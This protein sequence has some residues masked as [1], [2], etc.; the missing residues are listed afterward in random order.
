MKTLFIKSAI[1]F[2]FGILIQSTGCIKT[3]H[4]L[5]IEPDGGVTYKLEHSI[6]EHAIVQLKAMDKLRVQL[7]KAGSDEI[8][9]DNNHPLFRAFLDPNA[10]EIRKEL[11]P[12]ESVGVRIKKLEVDARSGWAQVE[13]AL[14]A[15]NLAKVAETDFFKEHGFNIKRQTNKEGKEQ[16]V[17]SRDAHVEAN[18]TIVPTL[19]KKEEKELIPILGGFETSIKITVPGRIVNSTAFGTTLY[20]ASW[21]FDFDREANALIAL[22]RQPLR[23]VFESINDQ[24]IPSVSYNGSKYPSDNHQ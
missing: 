9:T 12:F 11:K 8:T 15:D 2:I 23:I 19:S 13:M 24:H 18:G 14:E 7:A 10:D 1:F 16:L 20:T 21:E 17:F 4:K 22:Q 6:S 5:T 3:E